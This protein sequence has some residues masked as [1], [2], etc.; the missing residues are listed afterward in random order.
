MNLSGNEF[1]KKSYGYAIGCIKATTHPVLREEQIRRLED[2][3]EAAALK[4][5]EEYNYGTGA[6]EN[7][8]EARIEAEMR[9]TV[10]FIKDI[11][12]DAALLGPMLFEEDARNLKLYLKAKLTGQDVSGLTSDGGQYPAELMRICAETEDFSLLGAGLEKDLD[13]IQE[14]TDPFVI[15][16]RVDGAMYANALRAAKKNSKMLYDLL[17]VYGAGIN[18]LTALR[19]RK[20]PGAV[21]DGNSCYL[22]VAWEEYCVK[23]AEKTPEEVRAE[24]DARLGTALYDMRSGEKFAPI[25]EYFF[26]KRRE[27]Q[28]LRLI[29]AEKAL[30]KITRD[31]REES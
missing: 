15:S 30:A 19:L 10:A 8:A 27:A 3:D 4:L 20:L 2:A 7:S 9:Y 26:S 29:F 31:H 17:C 18:R 28:K 25:A 23:D 6:E 24:V 5:L 13:G 14:E 16:S 22:P 1:G 11:A 21:K 12:P